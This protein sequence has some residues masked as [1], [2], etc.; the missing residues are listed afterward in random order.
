MRKL[1]YNIASTAIA[2]SHSFF[3]WV[4]TYLHEKINII[5]SLSVE[6]KFPFFVLKIRSFVLKISS[7]VLKIKYYKSFDEKIFRKKGE[8]EEVKKNF[9][10]QLDLQCGRFQLP[11]LQHNGSSQP[12]HASRGTAPKLTASTPRAAGGWKWRSKWSKD[13]LPS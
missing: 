5:R 13:F 12:F 4:N 8:W 6:L 10:F 9:L 11:A 2:S 7:F 1:T 3:L